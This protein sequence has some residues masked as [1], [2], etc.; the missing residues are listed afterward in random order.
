[1]TT[2]KFGEI[3]YVL[4]QILHLLTRCDL[5]NEHG[6][7]EMHIKFIKDHIPATNK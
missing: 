4:V 1:M 7:D 5:P 3:G 2:Q 6:I